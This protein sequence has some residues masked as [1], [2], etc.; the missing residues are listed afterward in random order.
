MKKEAKPSKYYFDKVFMY[1]F[2]QLMELQKLTKHE[3]KKALE[4]EFSEFK[5]FQPYFRY[6]P[7][8]ITDK[9]VNSEAVK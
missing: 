5:E 7:S 6:R 4:L 1:D 2:D 8:L 9:D 3:K